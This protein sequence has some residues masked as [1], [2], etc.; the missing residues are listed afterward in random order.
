MEDDPV[1]VLERI[2]IDMESAKRLR[3][4]KSFSS[5]IKSEGSLEKTRLYRKVA[6]Q[7][8][9]AKTCNKTARHP[10]GMIWTSEAHGLRKKRPLQ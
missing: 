7:A 5:L 4:F 3:S 9:L 10:R 1:K 6:C 2:L 8:G